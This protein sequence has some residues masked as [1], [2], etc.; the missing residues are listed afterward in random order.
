MAKSFILALIIG[1]EF[2]E[3]FC[4]YGFRALLFYFLRQA[5]NLS[6]S[7][8]TNIVHLFNA[9]CFIATFLGGILSDTILGRYNTILYLSIIYLIGTILATLSTITLKLQVLLSG[10]FL[11]SIGTG[12]IKPCV[13]TFGGD[14]LESNVKKFFNVFYFTINAGS[15]LG[16]FISPILA[17]MQCGNAET[18]YPL[19]FG[20]PSLLLLISM[21]LFICGSSYYVKKKP[22]R[23]ILTQITESIYLYITYKRGNSG[24]SNALT[25]NGIHEYTKKE[26]YEEIIVQKFGKQFYIDMQTSIKILRLF[27]LIPFFWMLY[28]QQSTTWVEQASK[29]D[30]NIMFGYHIFPTQMQ[31]FN[32]ILILVFIPIFT[33]FIYP[34]F[35]IDSLTKMSLGIVLA[36]CSF[37]FSAYIEHLIV[38]GKNISLLWQVPQ[39]VILTAGEVLLS[40]TGIE[41]VYQEAPIAMKGLLLAGWLITV[42]F[43]NLYVILFTSIN[44]FGFLGFKNIDVW[45]YIFYGILGLVAAYYFY[46]NSLT[47]KRNELVI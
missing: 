46:R 27:I 12:G 21:V 34:M 8:S 47:Y 11:I 35:N 25:G 4:Y 7:R 1:N 20:V 31:A 29:M 45:N 28:D 19:A 5:Y 30:T 18:C 37:F 23:K 16:I 43:G 40:M 26:T 36:S 13:S 33:S 38:K 42:A 14:Q 2:C 6:E 24:Y 39:Y 17:N 9:S 32:G 44:I 10:L 22:D 3:R 41:F 15:L